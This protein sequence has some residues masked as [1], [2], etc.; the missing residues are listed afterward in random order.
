MGSSIPQRAVHYSCTAL[1]GDGGTERSPLLDWDLLATSGDA[2]KK[3]RRAAVGITQVLDE[4]ANEGLRAWLLDRDA[5]TT[6]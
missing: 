6:L 1:F 2:F 4:R 5:L 3:I